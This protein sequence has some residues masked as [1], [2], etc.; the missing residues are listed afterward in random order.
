MTEDIDRLKRQRDEVTRVLAGVLLAVGGPVFVKRRVLQTIPDCTIC[1]NDA[2]D[3][4]GFIFHAHLDAPDRI[5]RL[6]DSYGPQPAYNPA[7]RLA[8][9]ARVLPDGGGFAVQDIDS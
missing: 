9:I 8:A 5:E 2:P 3:G 1:K 7:E 6:R 4:D